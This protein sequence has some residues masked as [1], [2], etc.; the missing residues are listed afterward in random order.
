MI[1]YHDF[2][3]LQFSPTRVNAQM[4]GIEKLE[5]NS[6]D[7]KK[8]VEIIRDMPRIFRLASPRSRIILN[9]KLRFNLRGSLASK[10]G[11]LKTHKQAK[12][13]HRN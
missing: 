10:R 1:E 4:I 8:L 6:N 11:R 5:D 13:A 7:R 2:Q 3:P 9:M 12:Q